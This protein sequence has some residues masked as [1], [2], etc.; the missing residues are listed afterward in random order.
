MDLPLPGETIQFRWIII[1]MIYAATI[2][3]SLCCN[4][5]DERLYYMTTKNNTGLNEEMVNYI[6]NLNCRMYK[7]YSILFI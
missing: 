7:R 1:F 4:P 6:S 3:L 2:T 5:T